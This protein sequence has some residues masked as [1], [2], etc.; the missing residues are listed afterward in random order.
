[1][2][3]QINVNH[4]TRLEHQ[5]AARERVGRSNG[6]PA[7][8]NRP[9][10]ADSVNLGSNPAAAPTYAPAVHGGNSETLRFET[11][12]QLVASLLGK[13][14][15]DTKIAAGESGIDL[16]AITPAEAEALVGADGYCG[17][18]QTAERI[19]QFAVGVAGNDPA[20]LD[21][22]KAGIDRGF[23]EAKEALGDWLP[24][25]SYATYDAVL[26]KLDEWAAGTTAV[27]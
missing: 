4:T 15:V 14:G 10:H 27:V 17:V 25:I 13:Q 5:A 8:S 18:E 3:M 23:A 7:P 2:S 20:R 19:F 9:K 16:A 22:I 6:P 12:R 1:M 21:A 24:E 11:L 26:A